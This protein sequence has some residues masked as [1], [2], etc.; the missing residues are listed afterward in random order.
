MR[1][2]LDQSWLPWALVGLAGLVFLAPVFHVAARAVGY[3]EPLDQ[4]AVAT[5][6]VD[7]ATTV[8]SGVIPGYTMPGTESAIGTLVA[9]AIGTALTFVVVL[10]FGRLI[11]Q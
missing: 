2:L 10:G 1:R 3:T 9:A 11:E 5:G 8:H 4:V 7:A 6:A